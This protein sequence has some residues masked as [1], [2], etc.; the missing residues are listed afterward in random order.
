MKEQGESTFFIWT[1]LV[2]S[3]TIVSSLQVQLSAAREYRVR[4]ERLLRSI[5]E[6]KTGFHKQT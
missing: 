4:I 6:L 5:S 3:L 2:H 1:F